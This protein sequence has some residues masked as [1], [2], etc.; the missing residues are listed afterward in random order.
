[1]IFRIVFII[2]FS[3]I[4]LKLYAKQTAFD[5]SSEKIK[6][7]FEDSEPNLIIFGYKKSKGFVVL[8][9]RGPQQK[10]ILQNKKKILGMWTWKKSG[11]FTYPAL[12]HFY[13]NKKSND[14]DFRIKKDLFDNIKLKGKDNDNLKKDLI[15]KK[16]ALGLFMVKNSSLVSIEETTPNFFKIPIEV[17]FNAPTGIYTVILELFDKNGKLLESSTKKV[18]VEKTGLNSM[19]F[20]LAHRYSFF[21]G[22]VSVII[23]ILLGISA[24]L[25]FRRFF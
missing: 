4:S 3:L 7:D 11:E 13:T 20:Y 5:L 17:P 23:A 1:M 14:I 15:E 22:F 6:I 2:L 9:I 10:V 18:T 25:I 12:Y 24:G 16:R 8:K 21:Y 19:I